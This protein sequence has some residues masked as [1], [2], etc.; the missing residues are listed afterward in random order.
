MVLFNTHVGAREQRSGERDEGGQGNQEY[1]ELIDEKL[2]IEGD[3]RP[4]LRLD[5]VSDLL[6][7]VEGPS[8]R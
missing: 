7:Q 2:F 8:H 4:G 5:S 6:E 1:V 3:L